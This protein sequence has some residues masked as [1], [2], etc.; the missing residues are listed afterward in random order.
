MAAPL[1]TAIRLV[2]PARCSVCGTLV[3]SDFGICGTCWRDT[4]FIAGMCCDA[5]GVPLPGDE[6][7]GPA[8]CDD[9]MQ[10]ARPWMQGRAAMLYRDNGRKLVLALKHGDRHDVVRPA[11]KW[12][13]RTA[14]PLLDP[15]TLIA[16]VPLHWLRMIARR[17]NQSALLSAAL[18]RQTSHAHCPDLL[19][20]PRRTRTLAGMTRDA[21]FDALE[22]AIIAHPRRRHRLAGRKLLL[23]DDV[24]TTGATLASAAQAC[25]AAGAAEVRI[26][27]LARAAKDD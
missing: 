26:V 24:M 15:D 20:R 2:Y 1:Q 21:R 9:C 27:T 5:C 11:A 25:Y 3:E 12:L 19:L 16:P 8:T 4:P 10:T 13:A 23:V 18:A 7:G 22:G 6:R 17:Y 14:R